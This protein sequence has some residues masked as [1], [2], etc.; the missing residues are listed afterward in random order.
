M[1][2]PGVKSGT[3]TQD[4]TPPGA[5]TILAFRQVNNRSLQLKIAEPILDADGSPLTGFTGVAVVYGCQVPMI[6]DSVEQ[7]AALPGARRIDIHADEFEVGGICETTLPIIELGR[8]H[9]VSVYA[10]DGVEAPAASPPPPPPA[11]PTSGES[12]P[13]IP[14]S[15]SSPPAPSIS[16]PTTGEPDGPSISAPE[17]T[18]TAPA[19]SEDVSPPASDGGTTSSEPSGGISG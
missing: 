10:T 2:G 13:S 19:P 18:D 14:S 5:V 15:P 11:D 3:P 12:A 7:D 6:G 1:F 17:S 4:V 16:S 9:T 8:P